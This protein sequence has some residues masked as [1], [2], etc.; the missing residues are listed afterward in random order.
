M[1][2]DDVRAFVSVADSGS[3]SLAAL[4]FHVTQSAVTRRLQRLESSL[5]KVLL[6]RSTP[7]VTR[8]APG[9]CALERCRRLLSQARDVR[10]V[11]AAG[12]FPT[13]EMR[14]G[15]AHALT[16]LAIS[17]SLGRIRSEFPKIALRLRTGWSRELL[18]RVRNGALDA[19]LILLPKGE[20]LPAEII[21]A[22]L[23]EERVVI[24][25]SREHRR[26]PKKIQDLA[27]V[28]WIL[29]PGGC[30]ARATLQRALLQANLDMIVAVEAYNYELQLTLVAEN[31]GLTLVP[32]RILT[33]SRMRSRLRT[34]RV[35]GLEF[36]LTIWMVH[37]EPFKGLDSVVAEMNRILREKLRTPPPS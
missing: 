14:I 18:E 3:G 29:N 16:E 20:Q 2:F 12:D 28:Q 15:V 22:P 27:G 30:A 26:P 6:G 21:G 17:D 4:D 24:V 37:R 7:P 33:R 5:G 19:A 8:T 10:A 9:P 23:G 1:E 32:G 25:A 36:P 31:R 13:G 11:T 35:P 34:L